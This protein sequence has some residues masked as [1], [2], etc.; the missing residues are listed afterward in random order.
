[1]ARTDELNKVLRSLRSGA[2]E[3]EASALISEDGLM[4]ASALPQHLDEMRIAG[5]SSTLLSLGTRATVELQRGALE[6]VLIRGRHGYV[7]MVG[8]TQGTML[9]ALATHDAKLGLVF[10]EMGKAV[11]DITR[12]LQD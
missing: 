4:I 8:A 1:M 7:V 3:I 11:Q 12:I 6:Q 10:L 2:P 9:L 5:M